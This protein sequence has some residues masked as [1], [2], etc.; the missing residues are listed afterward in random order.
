MSNDPRDNLAAAVSQA[1]VDHDVWLAATGEKPSEQLARLRNEYNGKR[2]DAEPVDSTPPPPPPSHHVPTEKA[3]VGKEEES[4]TGAKVR[5]GV[6]FTSESAREARQ[7]RAEKEAQRKADALRE[8]ALGHL[9]TRQ[10]LGLALAKVSQSDMDAV[11]AQ[12]VMDAKRGDVKSIHALAR[13]L[14]QS[15]GRSGNEQ[16]ADDRPLDSKTFEEMTP[17][18]RATYREALLAQLERE[19]ADSSA[20]NDTTDPRAGSVTSGDAG[21]D[22]VTDSPHVIITSDYVGGH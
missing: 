18:E 1:K 3:E 9:T 14:D 6:A 15:F 13:I 22:A 12:L 19:K 11:V 4:P 2:F 5:R 21:S 17:A 7:V 20:S 16:V 8:Q 10:R